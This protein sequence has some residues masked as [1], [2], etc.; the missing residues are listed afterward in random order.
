MTIGIGGE[1]QI[2]GKVKEPGFVMSLSV[3]NSSEDVT[4]K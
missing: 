4:G 2:Q 1:E 3:R